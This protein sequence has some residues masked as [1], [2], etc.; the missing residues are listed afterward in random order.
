MS[1]LLLTD[2]E[3]AGLRD[4]WVGVF[5]QRG[6]WQL[7]PGLIENWVR[8]N[9]VFFEMLARFVPPGSSVLE[10][11]CGPGRHALGAAS[12][13]YQVVGIDIDPQIVAQAQANAEVLEP[14]C[15]PSFQVGDIF[16]LEA[17]A[18]PGTFRAVTHGG[19]MEHF[20]SPESIRAS[21]SYQLDYVPTVVF[22]VPINSAKNLKLFKRDTIF[23]QLWTEREW[24]DDVLGGLSIID[25]RTD[26]HPESNMT[27]DL[28]VVL[29]A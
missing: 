11:G 29:R 2:R 26:F 16:N 8:R 22:D 3:D 20:E 6:V 27:D 13:G 19:V 25:A 23:R 18:Q 17:V 24:L 1:E 28:V 9:A 4:D 14:A 10:L 7:T 5:Q 12:L 21:L 15:R